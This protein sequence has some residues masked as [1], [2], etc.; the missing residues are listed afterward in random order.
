MLVATH[1]L[2]LIAEAEAPVLTLKG[3][4]LSGSTQAALA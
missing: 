1:D 4:K 2:N 3:G